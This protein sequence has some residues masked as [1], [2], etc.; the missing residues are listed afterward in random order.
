[1]VYRLNK[2]KQYNTI[3]NSNMYT[4]NYF[5][6]HKSEDISCRSFNEK[7]RDL[8]CLAPLAWP[9]KLKMGNRIGL[10]PVRFESLWYLFGG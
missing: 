3:L 6:V 5:I 2:H 9:S 1:M 10:N 4:K 7:E 8:F